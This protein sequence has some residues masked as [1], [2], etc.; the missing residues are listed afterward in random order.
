MD[1]NKITQRGEFVISTNRDEFDIEPIHQLLTTTYW[2]RERSLET[3]RRSFENSLPFVI[4]RGDEIIG[5]ARIVSDFA[6]FAWLADVFI[7]EEFRGQGLSKWLMETIIAHEDLQGL[8]RWVLATRDAH[9]LYE[10]FGFDK[11]RIPHLWMEKC[12]PNAYAS[13]NVEEK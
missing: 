8:R 3:V 13:F 9:G 2:A 12:A 11:M 6:T 4:L 1:K 10:Q 7:R 5:F